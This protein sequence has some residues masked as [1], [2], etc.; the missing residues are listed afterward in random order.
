MP[1]KFELYK[2]KGGKF[3]FRLKASNGQIILASQGYKS[4]PSATNGIRSVQRNAVSDERFARKESKGRYMFNLTA[5]N[6]QVVGTSEMYETE[7][8]RDAGVASVAKNAPSA[9]I[10][11]LTKT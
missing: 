9:K 10:D 4:K 11:D 2:D 1:G 8:A 3:R 7:R 6:G 5:T